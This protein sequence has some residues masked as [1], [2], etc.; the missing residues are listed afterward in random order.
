LSFFD[1]SKFVD[2]YAT[3][4]GR[5]TQEKQA[6]LQPRQ[7]P[8]SVSE[9]RVIS[10]MDALGRSIEAEQL[11]NAAAGLAAARRRPVRRKRA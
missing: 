2:R 4:T 1:P 10:L 9:P 5:P 11:K 7:G 8:V 6:G 3:G